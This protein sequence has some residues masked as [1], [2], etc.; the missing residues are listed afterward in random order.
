MP[1]ASTPLLHFETALNWL[2]GDRGILHAHHISGPIYVS[3]PTEFKGSGK[4]WSP[5]HLFLGSVASCYMSTF[6]FFARKMQLYFNHMECKVSGEVD[7]VNG[8]YQFRTIHLYP[9]VYVDAALNT[10][11]VEAVL[12][13]TKEHCLV[14][15]ALSVPIEYHTAIKTQVITAEPNDEKHLTLGEL[16]PQQ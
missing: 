13:K 9:T 11:A 12:L 1:N 4:D 15:N 16:R 14:S 2:S 6:L 5:E 3:T 7:L 8:K 10:K